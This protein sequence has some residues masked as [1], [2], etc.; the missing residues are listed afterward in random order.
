MT[1]RST[2][3][4]SAIL[5]GKR[6][7]TSPKDKPLRGA[8]RSVAAARARGTN[9]SNLSAAEM[10]E[11]ISPD[12]PLTEKQRLFV[13]NWATGESVLS[14]SN[15]AGYADGG[16]MAYRLVKMPNVLKLYHEE[17]AKYETVAD[18]SRKKVMD[19]LVESYGM[20]KLMAEPASMVSAARE[21]GKMC[22]YYAPVETRI[23]VDVSGNIV[24]DRMN[25]LSDAELL[26]LINGDAP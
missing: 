6:R 23:K 5:M 8:G 1:A 16:T 15:R 2:R 22:G 20:A 21:I 26:K 12:K 11:V 10:A 14:A 24:L 7:D 3:P 17:K 25:K 13:Q 18:M 19:M 4:E 9:T